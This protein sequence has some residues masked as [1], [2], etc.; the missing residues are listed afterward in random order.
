MIKGKKNQNMGS[1]TLFQI[2]NSSKKK[3]I[4]TFDDVLVSLIDLHRKKKLIP[5]SS[6]DEGL[7]C[8]HQQQLLGTAWKRFIFHCLLAMECAIGV[9]VGGAVEMQLLQL[10]LASPTPYFVDLQHQ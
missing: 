6:S 7:W 2:K 4:L 1:L 9:I 8:G 5:A 10:L 3:T